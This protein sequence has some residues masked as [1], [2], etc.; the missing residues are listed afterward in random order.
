MGKESACNVADTGDV[1]SILQVGRSPGGAHGN[2]IQY[3]LSGNPHGE[4]HQAC[5]SPWDHRVRHDLATEQKQDY[6]LRYNKNY[7]GLER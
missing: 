3:F 5:H 1:D 4:R 2:P 6:R 7:R